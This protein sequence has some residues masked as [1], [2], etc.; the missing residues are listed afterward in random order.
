MGPQTA[1]GGIGKGDVK[2][3]Q[4]EVFV[5]PMTFSEIRHQVVPIRGFRIDAFSRGIRCIPDELLLGHELVQLGDVAPVEGID[6]T[7]D[8][9]TDPVR[10]ALI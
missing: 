3:V 2:R 6:E 4:H 8:D 9:L 7:L 5:L 10:R 1:S